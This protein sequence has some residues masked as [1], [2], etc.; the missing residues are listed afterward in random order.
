MSRSTS[1]R[2]R[3]TAL[4]RSSPLACLVEPWHGYLV[5]RF[6]DDVRSHR[7]LEAGADFAPFVTEFVLEDRD[8]ARTR[9]DGAF[10]L[11]GKAGFT[12]GEVAVEVD[13]DGVERDAARGRPI[14]V[15][16]VSEKTLA[17]RVPVEAQALVEPNETERSHPL[18]QVRLQ[19]PEELGRGVGVVHD[20]PVL[21]AINGVVGGECWNGPFDPV[22]EPRA[23]RRRIN[24]WNGPQQ[25]FVIESER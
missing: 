17:W 15:V 12:A 24:V 14:P 7:V 19:A 5:W 4:P 16:H 6:E 1:N 22:D 13:Q 2:C 10:E 11:L 18:R 25:G 23:L 21:V 3:A 8:E 9:N 20:D